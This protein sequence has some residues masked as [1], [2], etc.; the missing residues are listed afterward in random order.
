MEPKRAVEGDYPFGFLARI[1]E[2]EEKIGYS[3]QNKKFC[4]NPCT[5]TIA[6]VLLVLNVLFWNN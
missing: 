1:A 4:L 5:N 3:F 2:L 6:L